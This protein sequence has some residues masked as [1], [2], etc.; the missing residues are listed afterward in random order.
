MITDKQIA[1]L[2]KRVW[3][4]PYQFGL[5]ESSNVLMS[6]SVATTTVIPTEVGST[7]IVGINMSADNDALRALWPIP[8]DLDPKFELGFKVWWTAATISSGG[9]CLWTIEADVKKEGIA[10]A[11]ASTALDT[12]I[13]SD[14][15]VTSAGAATTTDSLLQ[16]TS[17]GI[18]NTLAI[19]RDDIEQGCT[20]SID[21]IKTS[22]TDITTVLFL[23]LMI[24]YAPMRCWGVGNELIPS[25]NAD[26]SP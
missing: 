14:E 9:D 17:R 8:Y 2:R 3:L 23:G 5:T 25:L 22:D 24:D 26:R 12:A 18:K 6:A 15:Y 10:I 11:A 16:V 19:T 13:A 20:L 21:L 4:N 1:W 7:G